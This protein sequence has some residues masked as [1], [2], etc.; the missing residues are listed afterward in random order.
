MA[1]VEIAGSGISV[2]VKHDGDLDEATTAARESWD[3]ARGVRVVEIELSAGGFG[4]SGDR[5][6]GP[7]Y[8]SALDVDLVR[9]PPEAGD[10]KCYLTPGGRQC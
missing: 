3:H 6:A 1:E 4:F 5:S 9:A 7:E 8:A 2:T 10:N